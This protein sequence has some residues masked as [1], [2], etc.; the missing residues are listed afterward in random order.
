MR[1]QV[2]TAV[3]EMV[4]L[5]L[6]SSVGPRD[7][8]RVEVPRSHMHVASSLSCS[9][10]DNLCDF[11]LHSGCCLAHGPAAAAPTDTASRAEEG[12]ERGRRRGGDDEEE[13]EAQEVFA[14]SD[15]S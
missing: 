1:V 5:W 10:G 8:S 6:E 14:Q 9:R 2:R 4:L 15:I 13:E 11:R 7:R 3:T 12:K